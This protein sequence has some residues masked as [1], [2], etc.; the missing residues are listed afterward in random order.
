MAGVVAGQNA[1]IAEVSDVFAGP[2]TDDLTGEAWRWDTVHFNEDGLREHGRRWAEAIE[3][4]QCQGFPNVEN[5]MPC[6]APEEPDA[7]VPDAAMPAD[8]GEQPMDAGFPMDAALPVDADLPEDADLSDVRDLDALMADMQNRPPLDAQ[9]NGDM[10]ADEDMESIADASPLDGGADIDAQPI[11]AASSMT[12]GSTF[13]DVSSPAPDQGRNDAAEGVDA[14]ADEDTSSDDA[15]V[16]VL[17]QDI[18][19]PDGTVDAAAQGTA[20]SAESGL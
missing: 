6:E 12:D 17:D 18:G 14:I 1:V 15:R 8:A 16:P 4:P 10:F 5:V 7:G 13:V 3:L 20:D 19:D 9:T 2:E 11:D